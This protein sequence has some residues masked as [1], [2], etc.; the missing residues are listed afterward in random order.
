MDMMTDLWKDMFEARNTDEAEQKPPATRQEKVIQGLFDLFYK[1]I[2]EDIAGA[3][4]TSYLLYIIIEA[5][6][7]GNDI[8]DSLL[9]CIDHMADTINKETSRET[10]E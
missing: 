3:N 4:M 7:D 6:R 5:I 9:L 2:E 10:E 8:D 1:H